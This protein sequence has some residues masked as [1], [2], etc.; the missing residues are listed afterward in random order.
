M[1]NFLIKAL[2][3]VISFIIIL[4]IMKILKFIWNKLV[5]KFILFVKPE[6]KNIYD[7][8][9]WLGKFFKRKK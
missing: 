6:L 2:A 5:W 9:L 8:T 7:L 1:E 4:L 3:V